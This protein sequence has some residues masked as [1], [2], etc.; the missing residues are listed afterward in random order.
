MLTASV[1]LPTPPLT[2]PTVRII[3]CD[4][5]TNRR[6]IAIESK[7]NRCT[8]DADARRLADGLLERFGAPS[9]G[10]ASPVPVGPPFT[11]T[12]SREM[13]GGKGDTAM[14]VAEEE[15]L[16]RQLH[17]RRPPVGRVGRLGPGGGRA[18][19]RAASLGLS[20]GRAFH[21]QHA[22]C[23]RSDDPHP[24]CPVA[25]LLCLHLLPAGVDRGPRQGG[26][27]RCRSALAGEE[28]STSRLRG[29][30]LHRLPRPGR[31]RGG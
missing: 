11:R 24:G 31:R 9:V 12:G 25:G 27:G 1:V 15:G 8:S 30:L 26:A 14:A 6:L 21:H 16:L 7:S 17:R 20:C 23:P 28:S 18:H 4:C 2:L 10:L 19:R 22:P 13:D 5:T 29:C 3:G